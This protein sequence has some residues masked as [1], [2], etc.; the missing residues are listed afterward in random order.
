MTNRFWTGY[1]LFFIFIF[2]MIFEYGS[3]LMGGKIDSS[4]HQS[5]PWTAV[6]YL[7]I[8][9]VAWLGFIV[10]Y[11]RRFVR[12]LNQESKNV[13]LILREGVPVR[14][15]V[16]KKRILKEMPDYQVLELE[17]NV[18][19]LAGTQVRLS[20][21]LHD[22]T[23]EQKR[24]EVGKL[25][26]MRLDPQLRSPAIVPENAQ[27][28][29]NTRKARSY[30]YGFMTLVLFCIGYLVF[31]YWLQSNGNGWRFLHFWHPWV[32]IP[33]WGLLFGW[34][35]LEV[36]VGKLLGSLGGGSKGEREL[37][38]KGKAAHATV[39]SAEQTGTY[40]NEQPQIRFEMEFTDDRGQRH[41]ASFKK[42]V[43]LMDLHNVGQK[44]RVI[45]YLPDNPQKIMLADGTVNS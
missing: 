16:E 11:Y 7:A 10:W 30:Y 43:S 32:T 14:A 13:A 6:T 17:L 22:T 37:I 26:A 8:G 39:I 2:P 27:V 38:F 23:P 5:S 4:F 42:I 19:N 44:Y 9:T 36:F 28:E 21:E 40:I 29:K 1:I 33:F 3:M 35:M 31:S 45:L 34:L 20:Y 41:R 18:K 12:P 25:I 15:R 24:Y